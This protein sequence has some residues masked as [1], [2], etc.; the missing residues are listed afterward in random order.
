MM[1]KAGTVQFHHRA[2]DKAYN[3][4]VV[5]R[6]TQEA[7]ERQVKI[8]AFPEM[9]LTGYWHVRNLGRDQLEELAEPV[10]SGSSTWGNRGSESPHTNQSRSWKPVAV[11]R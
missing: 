6:F 2:N 7:V 9:C 5:E 1:L 11:P 8:L 3:M 10:P 4:S